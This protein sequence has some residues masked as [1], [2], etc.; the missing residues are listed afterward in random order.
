[1]SQ[2]K[3]THYHNAKC[4][5]SAKLDESMNR[6]LQKAAKAKAKEAKCTINKD[7]IV[8]EGKKKETIVLKDVERN[9]KNKANRIIVVA[10][11]MEK[12][13][14][15]IHAL[16]FPDDDTFTQ[17]F[18]ILNNKPSEDNIQKRP[19]S[20]LSDTTSLSSSKTLSLTNKRSPSNSI[21]NINNKRAPSPK[22][23]SS[24]SSTSSHSFGE[25]THRSSQSASSYDTYNTQPPQHQ[26]Q[27]LPSA[28]RDSG[29]STYVTT[30]VL[31][32][33]ESSKPAK[34]PAKKVSAKDVYPIKKAPAKERPR[35]EVN[36]LSYIPGKGMV[37]SSEKNAYHYKMRVRSDLDSSTSSSSSSSD[38]SSTS[39]I[40]QTHVYR[41]VPMNPSNGA[42]F[43][44]SR[45]SSRSSSSSS[46]PT[47]DRQGA[48]INVWQLQK[49]KSPNSSS[50]SSNSS[51]STL[52]KPMHTRRSR[53]QNVQYIECPTC[54]R[55]SLS[56]KRNK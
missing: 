49:P 5:K 45:S 36:Y 1:M 46:S 41:L 4:S 38:S 7:K 48:K 20:P 52:D 35:T 22:S 39:T 42:P 32:T 25:L 9:R 3:L 29:T 15:R 14:F 44:T 43:R 10:S 55:R 13:E 24:D 27:A 23:S 17:F 33:K 54:H 11:K 56:R 19:P 51:E 8:I 31:I 21:V 18:D 47:E 34:Q 50:S 40:E 30:D 6:Q 16:K 2:I 37:K 28:H 26:P 53:S 12:N